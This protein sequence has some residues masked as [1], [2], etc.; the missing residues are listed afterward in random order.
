MEINEISYKTS[1]EIRIKVESASIGVFD[2][3]TINVPKRRIVLVVSR[4]IRTA[5][6]PY[7]N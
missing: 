6:D 4:N 2:T 3:K 7:R 5:F 1:F